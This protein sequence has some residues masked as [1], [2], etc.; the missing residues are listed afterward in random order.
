LT[1]SW[2][3][4]DAVPV[5]FWE[6]ALYS[7]VNHIT[8]RQEALRISSSALV[9]ELIL[10][11]FFLSSYSEGV[12]VISVADPYPFHHQCICSNGKQL[13]QDTAG[14]ETE[15]TEIIRFLE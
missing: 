8:E 13:T 2:L 11:M 10:G 15:T 14:M 6:E 1:S 9:M 3:H 12:S 5:L 7:F 4:A